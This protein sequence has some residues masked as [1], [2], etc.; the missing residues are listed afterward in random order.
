MQFVR[1]MLVEQRKRLVGTVMTYVEKEVYPKLTEMERR[2]LR[3]RIL[4][5]VDSY[6]DVC[7]DMLKASVDD[8]L[9]LND[10]AARLLARLNTEIAS[11]KERV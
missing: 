4:T 1:N 9:L 7:L 3:K 2:A 6:H 8:G 10:E 5:A 11:L